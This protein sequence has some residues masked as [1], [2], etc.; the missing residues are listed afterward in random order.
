[1][2]DHCDL[3]NWK[4]RVLTKKA[5][6]VIRIETEICTGCGLCV[7]D[8]IRDAI[9]WQEGKAIAGTVE[10]NACGHCYAI[11]PSGA[12]TYRKMGV[13]LQPTGTMPAAED[14][15]YLMKSRRSIRRFSSKRVPDE[16]IR[17]I[18]DVGRYCPTSQNVQNVSFKVLEKCLHEAEMRIDELL[19]KR[20]VYSGEKIKDGYMFRK[21][22]V[23]IL[24]CS[25]N[26][27]NGALAAAYMELFAQSLGYGALY[28]GRLIE[29][30]RQ[31][32]ELREELGLVEGDEPVACLALGVA[33]VRYKRVPE[34]K[35]ADVEYL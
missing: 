32:P 11:C 31:F 29:A 24:I 8:C 28:V 21:A 10:C 14:V 16:D 33:A 23:A 19:I 6:E 1:M 7:N 4:G 17:R 13:V 25:K 15:E 3:W 27:V 22:P 12:V 20:N 5:D 9:V 2:W 34:R 18:L 35:C 26:P 30:I